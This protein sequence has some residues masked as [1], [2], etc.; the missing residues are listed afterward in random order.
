[1]HRSA[2]SPAGRE[3]KALQPLTAV[4]IIPAR[5]H[6]TRL[7]EKPLQDLCGAPLIARVLE[8]VRQSGALRAVLVA[9]DSPRIVEAVQAAGGRAVMTPAELPSGLDRVAE[10]AQSVDD[11]IIVNIQGDEPFVS[12][13]GLDH[14]VSLFG[15]PD[16][17]MGTLAAPFPAGEDLG[18]PNRVKVV[19]DRKGR[20]LYFSR[21]PIPHGAGDVS[22]SA[23]GVSS[24]ATAPLLHVG[25]YAYR[26]DTLF[27]LAR[28]GPCPLERAERLEQLRAL[29]NGIPIHVA[30][31]GY[32]SL[33][34]DTPGD[35]ER[36]RQL[37]GEGRE[38]A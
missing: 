30:V 38:M 34:I 1:M 31:G 11:D 15:N 20:A 7:P 21:S 6:S 3:A 33:G 32:G 8:R 10:A 18:D 12:P 19:V 23:I 22:P 28:Q 17:V 2:F 27:E 26:R 5:L 4:G 37:F 14:L 16:V 35:L 29:W 25:V 13:A 9:T 24:G 36:A